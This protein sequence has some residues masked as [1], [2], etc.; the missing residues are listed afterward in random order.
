MATTVTLTEYT[1]Y[2]AEANI[3]TWTLA[4][5]ETG[6]AVQFPGSTSK[7]VQFSGTFGAGGTVVLEGSNDGTTYFTLTD[8]DTNSLSKTSAALEHVY[9][10]TL[11]LRPRVTAGDGTTSIKIVLMVK[12]AK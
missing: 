7:S 10:N 4:N 11:Y 9:E 2:G 5:G 1:R 6:E 3:A 12:R 8:G